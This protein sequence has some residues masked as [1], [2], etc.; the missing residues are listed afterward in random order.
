EAV[1]FARHAQRKMIEDQVGPLR[2]FG[3]A[4][5]GGELDPC[6]PFGRRHLVA[7]RR[8]PLDAC[9]VGRAHRGRSL[10]VFPACT[11]AD[12]RTFRFPNPFYSTDGSCVISRCHGSMP[13]RFSN[14]SAR[15]NAAM[16]RPNGRST[17][18]GGL[19]WVRM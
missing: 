18:A 1:G 10:R 12:A 2:V 3:V 19:E 4:M 17:Q 13:R 5:S 7:N 9:N 16:M 14:A 8:L 15:S 6:L 11:Q